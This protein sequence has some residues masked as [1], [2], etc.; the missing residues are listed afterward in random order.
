[1]L[2]IFPQPLGS[3]IH[4]PSAQCKTVC[5]DELILNASPSVESVGVSVGEC[6]VK[7]DFGLTFLAR[8]SCGDLSPAA[9]SLRDLQSQCDR[10]L[11]PHED[12]S[13]FSYPALAEKTPLHAP[14]VNNLPID[15]L[16]IVEALR[17]EWLPALGTHLTQIPVHK[18]TVDALDTVNF[19]D[20]SISKHLHIYVDGS[21][22]S[23]RSGPAGATWGLC[24]LAATTPAKETIDGILGFLG[25]PVVIDPEEFHYI[26]VE[27][28]T[29][30]G[31]NFQPWS[32]PL[33]GFSPT[34]PVKMRP[35]VIR[36]TTMPHT[37]KVLSSS[38]TTPKGTSGLCGLLL[39]WFSFYFL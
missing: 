24:V 20:G 5:L 36:S 7:Q 25:G 37:P 3:P 12:S 30:G 22:G 9:V 35:L 15:S 19:T 10:I 23:E 39:R 1:M 18:A 16:K 31:E 26:G 13:L 4:S 14:N 21:G 6:D 8:D 34:L 28:F 32:G 29:N 27:S 33:L 11:C 2:L 17:K 38:T